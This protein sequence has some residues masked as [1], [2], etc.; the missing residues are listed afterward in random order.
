MGVL[1]GGLWFNEERLL[2]RLSAAVAMVAG[3]ALIVL[4]G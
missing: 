4:A 3:S 2:Q 1:Y